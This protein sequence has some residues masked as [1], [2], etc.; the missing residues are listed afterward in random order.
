MLSFKE[1]VNN[2]KNRNKEILEKIADLLR[3]TKGIEIYS[4]LERDEE[5][6][7][8]ALVP[9]ESKLSEKLKKIKLGIR[10]YNIGND[11]IY[12]LQ[13]GPKGFP[14]GV[15]KKLVDKE[16]IENL[17]DSGE[18]NTGAHN[19]LIRKIPEKLGKFMRK[20]FQNIEKAVTY[21]PNDEQQDDIYQKILNSI[22]T[23]KFD[24]G[25]KM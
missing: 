14:I 16:E 25:Y 8:F 24:P 6:Y 21:S 10:I 3:R 23:A 9:V 11:I 12:R 13:K 19:T 2:D 20:V 5:S 7:I 15:A 18:S 4:F 17:I 1:Y 22:L